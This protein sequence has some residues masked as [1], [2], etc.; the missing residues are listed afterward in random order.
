[1]PAKVSTLVLTAAMYTKPLE[2][3]SLRARTATA[4]SYSTPSTSDDLVRLRT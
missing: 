3:E 4:P 2:G 1:M